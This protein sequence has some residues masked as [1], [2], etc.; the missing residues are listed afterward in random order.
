MTFND[1]SNEYYT[2]AEILNQKIHILKKELKTAPVDMLSSI[3]GRIGIMYQMYLDCRNTAN[4]LALR[5]GNC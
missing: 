3:E 1:W 2:T 5:K 4:I